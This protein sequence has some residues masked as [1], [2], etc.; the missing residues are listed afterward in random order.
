METVPSALWISVFRLLTLGVLVG[1]VLGFVFLVVYL[2]RRFGGLKAMGILSLL[3]VGSAVLVMVPAVLFYV[4]LDVPEDVSQTASVVTT[5]GVRESARRAA[6][7]ERAAKTSDLSKTAPTLEVTAM[8]DALPAAWAS[9]ELDAFQANLYPGLFQCAPAI[10]NSI[11]DQIDEK[12]WLSDANGDSTDSAIRFRVKTVD[13]G[14]FAYLD[15]SDRDEFLASFTNSLHKRFPGAE[16]IPVDSEF[17]VSDVDAESASGG[18]QSF[19]I[20]LSADSH[21]SR[22][23]SWDSNQQEFSGR[24]TGV[25]KSDQGTVTSRLDFVD[26]PWVEHLD[27]LV[28]QFPNRRYLVGYSEEFASSEAVARQS[29]IDNARAQ[30]RVYANNG[31]AVEIQDRHVIDRFAQKL[32]R[33]YGDVWREAVLVDVT[34]A[35]MQRAAVAKAALGK[36]AW[37]F[38][39]GLI[40]TSVLL[41]I[42]TVVIC[43]AINALTQGYYRNSVW[44]VASFAGVLV[45]L[46]GLYLVNTVTF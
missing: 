32:T 34:S 38:H 1:I 21:S 25:L 19:F 41:I 8:S 18:S 24:V 46:L 7:E 5:S 36:H 20:T 11:G 22:P 17:K 33:P 45:A 2:V 23:T 15:D 37:T 29:A 16:V 30:V 44:W 40:T 28:S 43:F 42:L 26:K 10:A 31:Y 39:L 9:V 6:A 35:S 13:R 12:G 4:Q 14:Y 27:Q 3:I